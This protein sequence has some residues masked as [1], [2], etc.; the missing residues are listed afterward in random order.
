MSQ[1]PGWNLN[2]FNRKGHKVFAL[3]TLRTFWQN[4][5]FASFVKPLSTL[6]LKKLSDIIHCFL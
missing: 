6:R 2:P 3:S 5:D 1:E 4:P